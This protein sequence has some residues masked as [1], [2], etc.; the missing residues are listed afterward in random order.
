MSVDLRTRWDADVTPVEAATFFEID[1]PAAV[2]RRPDL[3]EISSGIRLRPLRVE[4][5][6]RSWV[7]DRD[8]QGIPR[9]MAG[10]EAQL[11]LR[12]TADQLA[13][14]VDDQI[15]PV[16]LMTAGTLELEPMRIGGLMDWWLVLRSLLDERPIHTPG[17]IDLPD[18]LGRSFSLDDDPAVLRAYL[19]AAGYL[20]LQGVFTPDEM[21]RISNDMDAAEPEYTDGDGHSWW[22]TLADGRRRVVRMQQFEDRSP[23]TA[24][25]LEDERLLALGRLPDC[26]HTVDWG[27]RNRVEALFK[28]LG[29]AQGISDVPWHKD[30]S[31]GRHSYECCS[32]TIGISVTGAGPTSGQLRVIPGSHRALVWPSLFD[33][34]DLDL[35]DLALA[36]ETGDVTVHLSCTL[37]MAQPPTEHER[38]VLYTGYRLPPRDSDAA[39]AGRRRLRKSRESAP[40]TTSQ[41]AAG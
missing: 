28:P 38:K 18:E 15:T 35:P 22:A 26:G 21:Q 8:A 25:L 7:L 9:A 24:A 19:E 10:D 41:V 34:S 33:A 2:E 11:T 6:G 37:H 29:V 4:V 14:L 27:R 32:L 30:C 20:H 36:T 5:D 1:W 16:G 23:T 40:L 3:V 39:D 17:A 13:D 31:L 12:L